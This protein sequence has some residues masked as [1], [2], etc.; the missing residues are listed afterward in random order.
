[1][2]YALRAF[3]VAL[4]PYSHIFCCL[5]YWNRFFRL[6]SSVGITLEHGLV[7]TALQVI[8]TMHLNHSACWTSVFLQ[9]VSVQVSLGFRGN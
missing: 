3:F 9:H 4:T 5:E 1:M 7:G 8:R 6:N 2:Q